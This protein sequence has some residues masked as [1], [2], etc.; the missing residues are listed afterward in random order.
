MFD[1]QIIREAVGRRF[2]SVTFITK[3]NQ[4]RPMVCKLPSADRFF[5]GGEL[6]GDRSRLLSVIDINLLRK[7]VDPK[8]AWR[9]INLDTILE[10]KFMGRD[11][12]N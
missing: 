8:R 11:W 3:D 1:K 2:F 9:S 12:V 7:G 10:F 4:V 5:S 6:K